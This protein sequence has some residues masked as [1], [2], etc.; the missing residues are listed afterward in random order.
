MSDNVSRTIGLF[1][2]GGYYAKIDEGLARSSTRRVNLR[3]LME[4]IT[5][6]T[7]KMD[8]LRRDKVSIIES[9]YFRST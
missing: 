1:I 7:C 9:H 4:F 3:A 6:Y 8:D 5:E 2:D